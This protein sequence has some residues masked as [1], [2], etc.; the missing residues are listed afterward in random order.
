MTV[1]TC[2]VKDDEKT[3]KKKHLIYEPFSVETG[4]LT[5]ERLAQES[6]KEFVG[7]PTDIYFNI[8]YTP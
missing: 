4:D 5:L 3:L 7:E 6:L 2:V 1:V 8:K